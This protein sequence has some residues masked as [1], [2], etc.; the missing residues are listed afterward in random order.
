MR[1]DNP[2]LT[3]QR[4]TRAN[5]HSKARGLGGS[6]GTNTAT[7]SNRQVGG[8]RWDRMKDKAADWM[9]GKIP[10]DPAGQA[11][12]AADWNRGKEKFNSF[13]YGRRGPR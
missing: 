4:M 10:D 3:V 8:G 11:Q 13:M 7:D 2:S 9:F 6:Y 1:S 12:Y 5:E